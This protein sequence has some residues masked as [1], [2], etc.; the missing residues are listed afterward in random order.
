[1]LGDQNS[2]PLRDVKALLDAV[3]IKI[4]GHQVRDITNDLKTNNQVEGDNL[5]KVAFEKV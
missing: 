1:M 2:V 5:S 3:G 4:P